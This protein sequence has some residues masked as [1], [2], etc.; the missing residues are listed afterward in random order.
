M[1][2][3]NITLIVLAVIA[4][5]TVG[6]VGSLLFN[7]ETKPQ[8]AGSLGQPQSSTATPKGTTVSTTAALKGTTVSTTP[9][10]PQS[11][12]QGQKPGVDSNQYTLEQA[13]SDNAQLSTIA[14]SG[15]AFITGSSGADTFMPPGK[16]AD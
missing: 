16:V 5:I 14:F 13:M 15:L 6:V 9:A 3:K 12:N 7:K 10:S 1:S 4:F 8:A 2:K 11:P